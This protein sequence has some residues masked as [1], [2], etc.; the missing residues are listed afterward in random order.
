M[1]E[2]M[3]EKKAKGKKTHG[4]FGLYSKGDV[5]DMVKV[6]LAVEETIR[7]NEKGRAA[8]RRKSCR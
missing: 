7:A 8:V 3:K 5:D 1:Q 2:H 6:L 4:H